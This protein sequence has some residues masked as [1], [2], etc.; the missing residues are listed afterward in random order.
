MNFTKIKKDFDKKN[1]NLNNRYEDNSIEKSKQNNK[2]MF[3]KLRQ[4]IKRL[5]DNDNEEFKLKMERLNNKFVKKDNMR[6]LLPNKTD[7]LR[8]RLNNEAVENDRLAYPRSFKMV[9]KAVADED[10]LIEPVKFRNVDDEMSFDSN[11]LNLNNILT[12]KARQLEDLLRYEGLENSGEDIPQAQQ[13]KMQRDAVTF[14]NMSTVISGYN[15]LVREYIKPSLAKSSKIIFQNKFVELEPILQTINFGISKLIEEFRDPVRGLKGVREVLIYLDTQAIIKSMLD[16]INSKS[17]RLLDKN[18]INSAFK[19]AVSD[20]PRNEQVAL[21]RSY[22]TDDYT[23]RPLQTKDLPYG[24]QIYETDKNLAINKSA[25]ITALENNLQ[26]LTDELND[27]RTYL[28]TLNRY[29]NPF[30]YPATEERIA[31][32]ERDVA[33]VQR[34]LDRVRYRKNIVV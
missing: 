16:Q 33:V 30:Q 22:M 19:D 7:M 13:L 26:T 20:L 6:N 24:Q 3:D 9:Q 4:N 11:L 2:S 10:N 17:Y 12:E 34:E 15:G 27:E 21:K 14:N 5:S 8:T 29:M 23:D 18:I 28:A 32:L 1:D 25:R 31:Q